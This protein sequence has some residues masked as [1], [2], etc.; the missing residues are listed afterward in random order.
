MP[1]PSFENGRVSFDFHDLLSN[2]TGEA[3]IQLIETLACDDEI[4]RHVSDQIIDRWTESSYQ[5]RN[6]YPIPAGDQHSYPLDKAWRAV[7]KASSS[8]AETEIDNLEKA[9]VKAREEAREVHELRHTVGRYREAL[10]HLLNP[11]FTL[12]TVR[13]L[14]FEALRHRT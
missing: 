10:T 6:T 3:R 14:A 4:F 13:T 11:D 9:L 12:P 7:A 8:V 5:A 1:S 2:F